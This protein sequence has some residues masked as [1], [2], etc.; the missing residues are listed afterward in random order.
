MFAFAKSTR[1][2]VSRSS[3]DTSNVGIIN[4]VNRV[5]AVI[6]FTLDGKILHANENFLK[7]VGY[8][9]EE[10][11]DNHHSMFVDADYRS[12]ADY[13]LFWERLGRGEYDAGQY[14][15]VGKGGRVV[16]IQ[17]SYNPIFDKRGKPFKVVKFATDITQ[18]KLRTADYEGQIAAIG[19]AQ[20][21]IEFT[22]DGKIVDANEQFPQ[23]RSVTRSTKSKANIT[24]C[25]SSP[26]IGRARNTGC[27]GKS[28]G[29]ANTTP[30]NTSASAKAATRSGSRR[31]TIRSWMPTASRSKSSNTP[32]TSPPASR[33]AK[34]SS[35]P[36]QQVQA[37]VE[38]AKNNDLTGRIPLDG[39]TGEIGDLC[40]GV[41]G[42][43]D[44]MMAC[45]R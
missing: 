43:L 13:R 5:Q 19:K 39:K 3:D 18:Q 11:K 36:S 27:S 14:K 4:A 1:N 33:P 10:I 28:S 9:L 8:S 40:A 30:R 6:E 24:P 29:A 22:L 12:S 34:R 7:T 25:S 42:L 20:A 26:A 17:A 31:A 37:V 41:N 2:G 21:V 35:K 38:A 45:G 23:S 16:W 32:P 15:R 44:T